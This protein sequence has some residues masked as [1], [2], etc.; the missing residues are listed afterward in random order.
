MFLMLFSFN[1]KR[2]IMEETNDCAICFNSI[3]INNSYQKWNCSHLF[4]RNCIENWNNGCPTCRNQNLFDDG[5]CEP[6]TWSISRNH[7]NTLDLERMK[8]S[9]ILPEN[10]EHIYK[11]NW[12]DHDCINQNHKIWYFNRFGVVAI[13]ENCNTVQSFNQLH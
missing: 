1:K 11:N 2:N 9:N 3:D 5:Q 12:K 7:R 6:V 8:R 4:H 13:C 10:Y